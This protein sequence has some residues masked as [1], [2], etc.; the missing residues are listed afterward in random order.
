MPNLYRCENKQFLKKIN[1]Y[2]NEKEEKKKLPLK[3]RKN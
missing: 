1:N 3:K 2:E